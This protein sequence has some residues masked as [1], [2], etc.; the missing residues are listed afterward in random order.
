MLSEEL[1]SKLISKGI[2]AAAIE[3]LEKNGV[4]TEEAINIAS[5]S[6]LKE[7]GIDSLGDRLKIKTL[8]AIVS[9]VSTVPNKMTPVNDVVPEG[10][11]PSP[12]QMSSFANQFGMDPGIMQAIMF[13]SMTSGTGFDFDFSSMVPIGSIASSYSPKIRNMPYMFMGQVEKQLDTPIV[14][15]NA[16][17]SVNPELTAK[18]VISLQ[19]GFEPSEDGIYYSED[20]VPF[21]IT[22]V[23]V[24]AQSIYD[25]D[26]LDSSKALQKN[27]MGIG[28]ITWNKVSLDV[29]QMV[30][31]AVNETGELNPKDNTQVARLRDHINK[32]V[33]RMSLH[34]DFPKAFN[35][36]N[37]KN[38]TG[39]LPTLRVQLSRQPHK[40]E[41]MPRRRTLN[42][43]VSTEGGPSGTDDRFRG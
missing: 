31:L 36:Y 4:D 13:S 25:S 21:E 38:R 30:F 19:E 34:G 18:Y 16:D 9:P 35:L 33:T 41:V 12:D 2:S 15:I 23:G 32:D 24:D 20:S 37:E 43:S 5:D 42:K 7:I 17:G 8:S 22:K 14:V 29:R 11:A 40:N 27:G 10:A 1:K 3:A 26:P 39:S 6:D 28:R